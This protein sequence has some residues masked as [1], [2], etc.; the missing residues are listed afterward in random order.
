VKPPNAQPPPAWFVTLQWVAGRAERTK[1]V[2]KAQQPT[3]LMLP[4]APVAPMVNG[5]T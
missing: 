2:Q 5:K 1:H 4:N 3:I